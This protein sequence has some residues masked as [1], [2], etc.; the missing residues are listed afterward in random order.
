MCPRYIRYGF[1]RR[2]DWRQSDINWLGL[3][4]AM[5]VYCYSPPLGAMEETLVVTI[6]QARIIKVPPVPKR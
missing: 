6:D 2:F 1:T 4:A 3:I 5:V